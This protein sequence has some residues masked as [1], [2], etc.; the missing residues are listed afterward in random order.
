[1]RPSNVIEKNGHKI[2]GKYLYPSACNMFVDKVEYMIQDLQAEVHLTLASY[3][4]KS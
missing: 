2:L 4:L 3:L 1:M